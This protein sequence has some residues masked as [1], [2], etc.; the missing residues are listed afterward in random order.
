MK[1]QKNGADK[2]QMQHKKTERKAISNLSTAKILFAVYG[3]LTPV[4]LVAITYLVINSDFDGFI[5]M[6]WGREG[7][8]VLI[9]QRRQTLPNAEN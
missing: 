6:K 3:V 5:Q 2:K 9:D 4:V 1:S 7:G 8:E